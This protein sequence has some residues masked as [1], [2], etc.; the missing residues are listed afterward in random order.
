MGKLIKS[1]EKEPF[2]NIMYTFSK[3]SHLTHYVC[4]ALRYWKSSKLKL[5]KK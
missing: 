1:E 5:G 3:W 4:L 2:F